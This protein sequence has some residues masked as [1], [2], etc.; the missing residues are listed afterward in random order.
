VRDMAARILPGSQFF[1][2]IHYDS[3]GRI[4][5]IKMP[6]MIIHSP[7]DETI[8]YSMG[9]ELYKKASQPKEFLRIHGSHNGG[10]NESMS[11][12][13][14]AVE[15]FVSSLFARKNQQSP[16]APSGC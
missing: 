5:S 1:V 9:E 13:G 16:T 11:V 3:I 10:W 12:Y 8:P 2:Y 6:V 15:K 4:G 14:P 7:D